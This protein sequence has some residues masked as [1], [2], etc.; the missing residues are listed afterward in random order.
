MTASVSMRAMRRTSPP[1]RWQT[2][3]MAK[4]R[5]KSHEWGRS[6][7]QPRAKAGFLLDCLRLLPARAD[8]WAEAEPGPDAIR[9]AIAS[10][11]RRG[12]SSI[13]GHRLRIS[14]RA[15]PEDRRAGPD[16]PHRP[17]NQ[18]LCDR[19]RDHG[20]SPIGVKG[21]ANA[22]ESGRRRERPSGKNATLV[23][24]SR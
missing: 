23:T 9:T 16:L 22:V 11:N 20:A 14:P 5:L 17:R 1:Q 21:L 4:V 13:S 19:A 10:A 6:T 3:S 12:S 2:T 18:M 15:M 7:T 24:A 8:V